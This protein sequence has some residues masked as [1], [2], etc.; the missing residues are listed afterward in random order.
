MTAQMKRFIDFTP[1]DKAFLKELRKKDPACDQAFKDIEQLCVDYPGSTITHL[2][3]GGRSWGEQIK[4]IEPNFS[5]QTIPF[6]K[7]QKRRKK[8]MTQNER[9][10]ALT[11]YKE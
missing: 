6:D 8:L 11:T 3:C 5:A 4:P 1:E 2:A 9:R 7:E 10:R